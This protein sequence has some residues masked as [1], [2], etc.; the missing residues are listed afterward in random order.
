[1]L[2]VLVT[3]ISTWLLILLMDVVNLGGFLLEGT[4]A[5]L[6]GAAV[7]LLIPWILLRRRR[8]SAKA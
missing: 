2:A 7:G 6:G 4:V 3:A 5:V 8:N 1:M